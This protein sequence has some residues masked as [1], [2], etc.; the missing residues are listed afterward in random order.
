MSPLTRQGFGI[1]LVT[2]ANGLVDEHGKYFAVRP[3]VHRGA[4]RG[5]FALARK[6]EHA[7]MSTCLDHAVH[8]VDRS[9]SWHPRHVCGSHGRSSKHAFQRGHSPKR[10]PAPPHQ[11]RSPR[12]HALRHDR[13]TGR[14]VNSRT[15]VAVAAD[16]PH[17][18]SWPS[19]RDA[20]LTDQPCCQPKEH[21]GGDVAHK[22]VHIRPS[23]GRVRL[24]LGCLDQL[25]HQRCP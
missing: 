19:L 7:E 25:K 9:Q 16:L 1:H 17:T 20:L 4:S 5:L 22:A 14:M 24:V 12:R 21:R 6:N 3:I 18:T 15:G 13:V 23:P 8:L 10:G 2:V 11:Q